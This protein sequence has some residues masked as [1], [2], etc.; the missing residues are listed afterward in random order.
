MSKRILSGTGIVQYRV[1][2]PTHFELARL[3][4]S[5]EVCGCTVLN[6]CGVERSK[7]HNGS[8]RRISVQALG[9]FAG[10]TPRPSMPASETLPSAGNGRV[11]AAW[12]AGG[13]LIIDL[14]CC[15]GCSGPG[16]NYRFN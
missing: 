13:C 12:A 5:S 11:P 14:G 6:W 4:L 7:H 1:R 9:E 3:P 15:G 10:Y 8:L 16:I 2:W